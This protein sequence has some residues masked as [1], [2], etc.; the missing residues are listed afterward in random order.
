MYFQKI[1]TPLFTYMRCERDDIGDALSLSKELERYGKLLSRLK[2]LVL[3]FTHL[4]SISSSEISLLLKFLIEMERQKRLVR[5]LL[6]P[7]IIKIMLTRNIQKLSHISIYGSM[8]DFIDDMRA[9][10]PQE[11]PSPLPVCAGAL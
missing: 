4:S 1:E 2:S 9:I 3:D 5:L 8:Q 7:T 6:T 11:S 10:M